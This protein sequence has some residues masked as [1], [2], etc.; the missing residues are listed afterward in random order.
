M[1]APTA[2]RRLAI[3]TVLAAAL[4]AA[5]SIGAGS[6]AADPAG[7]AYK[8]DISAAKAKRAAALK[9]CKSRPTKA[10]RQ[11]C[12]K[13]AKAAYKSANQ[14]AQA[15]RDRARENA[16]GGGDDGGK[17]SPAERRDEYRD[18][19]EETRDPRACREASRP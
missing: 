4:V 9:K 17:E 18:C 7:E 12:R 8:A 10:K 3:L 15:K 16:G 6:A 5:L 1:T 13:K 11:A 19:V 2:G 14:K